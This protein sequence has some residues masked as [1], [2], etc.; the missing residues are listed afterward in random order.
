MNEAGI[1]TEVN[2][3]VKPN[4]PVRCTVV[5]W[6]DDV[7]DALKVSE[8]IPAGFEFVDSD[9][10]ADALEEVRDGALVHYLMNSGTPTHFRYY[11]R[12]EADGSLIALPAVAEYLRRPATRGNSAA[13]EIVVHP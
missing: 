5:V 11:L 7:S 1:W 9:F 4:E 3:V 8:P 2:G 13:S 6:G 10:T 12:A